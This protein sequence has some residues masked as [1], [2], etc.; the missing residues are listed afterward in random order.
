MLLLRRGIVLRGVITAIFVLLLSLLLNF[1]FSGF[2]ALSTL[3]WPI[4]FSLGIGGFTSWQA[5]NLVKKTF[6]NELASR[7]W[8]TEV[9][10]ANLPADM[11]TTFEDYEVQLVA[12]GYRPLGDFTASNV[13]AALT[14]FVRVFVNADETQLI[15]VQQIQMHSPNPAIAPTLLGTHFSIG[16]VMAGQIHICVTDHT[17]QPANYLMRGAYTAVATYPQMPLLE[18]LEKHRK[19]VTY[20]GEKT[21]HLPTPGL[22]LARNILFERERREQALARIRSISGWTLAGMC[23]Q[24]AAAP[25]T[26][27]SVSSDILKQ[28]TQ[29][30]ID[31]FDTSEYATPNPVLMLTDQ[32]LNAIDDAVNNADANPNMEHDEVNAAAV[33]HDE[34]V[35]PIPTI[36]AATMDK[37]ASAANWFYWIAALTVVGLVAAMMGSDWGFAIGLGT[38]QLLGMLALPAEI[39]DISFVIIGLLWLINIGL[40]ALFFW[41]GYAARRPSLVA[42]TLGIVLYLL[43]TLLFVYAEDWLGVIFHVIALYFLVSGWSCTRAAMQRIHAVA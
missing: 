14:A 41:F 15:E 35:R 18:L 9:E 16:T 10:K 6:T 43:D 2:S 17:V 26:Q 13:N 42:F 24:L 33:T 32:A 36:D 39:G 23:D 12:R 8:Y 40:I 31:W 20:I 34:V 27:W 25:K 11:A 38:S 29:R 21:G 22:T 1:A 30:P 28:L 3:I 37:I 19:L 7:Y 4:L 5:T